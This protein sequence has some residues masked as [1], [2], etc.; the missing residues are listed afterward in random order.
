MRVLTSNRARTVL[1]ASAIA[2]LVVSC[3]GDNG[4]QGPVA[5]DTG[6]SG[7][8]VSV[9]SVDGTDVLVDSEGHTLYTAEVEEG[10]QIRC[11][12]A[13]TSLWE[14]IIASAA[15]VDAVSTAL[16]D[17]LGVV[18]RPD[19]GSQLTYNG[20]PLYTFAEEGAGELRGDGISDDFQ[21]THFEWSAATT[22]ESG[23]PGSDAPSDSG[24]G[25]GY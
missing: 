18:D 7:S 11:V 15:E 19:G 12:D 16:R 10:G 4:D 13:C 9:A 14:P 20:L 3:G 2:V 21:G 24:D 17:E 5:G 1:A 6:S 25:Y 8:P 23:T 22:A